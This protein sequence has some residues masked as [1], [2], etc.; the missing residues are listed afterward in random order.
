[1][2]QDFTKGSLRTEVMSIMP[3]SLT[4]G[5]GEV[6]SYLELVN[7]LLRSFA[8]EASLAIQV[9]EFHSASQQDDEKELEY[10]D[11]LRKMNTLC[12]FIHEQGV[13]KGR[14]VEGLHWSVRAEVRE[15]NT[16][17]ISLSEL[18]RFA[19]RRGESYRKLR[20]EQRL[21]RLAEA[22]MASEAKEKRR[23][24][25][26]AAKAPRLTPGL[27]AGQ[28]G[29]ARPPYP[30]RKGA[31]GEDTRVGSHDKCWNCSEQGHWA[32]QCPKLDERLRLRLAKPAARPP[33][34]DG[35]F[36]RRGNPSASVAAVSS[37]APQEADSASS[38]ED[39]S[40]SSSHSSPTDKP[41]E[42]N[43]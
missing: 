12:G 35:P 39:S 2:L 1:M 8:D 13:I 42:G 33:R 29:P 24:A 31:T 37:T 21:E 7:W 28:P 16:P 10:A 19:Q 32:H 34:S 15:R 22:R 40:D 26:A 20:E 9:E 23:L 4:G 41:S 27:V 36:S 14:F 5:P 11:R 25:R 6:T 18:A 3:S 38:A 17:S 43:E 30:P